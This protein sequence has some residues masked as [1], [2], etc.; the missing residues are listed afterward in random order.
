MRKKWQV[1]A[2]LA[3]VTVVTGC[4]VTVGGSA[5]PVPGQGPVVTAVDACTLLDEA[6][7]DALGFE[8]PGRSVKENKDRLQPPMCLWSSKDDIEPSAVLNVGVAS[9]MDFNEYIS[10]AVKKSE[11][12][13]I[14]GFSWTQ[15]ASILPDDCAYYALLGAKSFAYVSVSAGKLDKSCELA[16][17]AIPQVAAHLPGGQDAP[18]ITPSTSAKPEPGGPLLSAD[19]CA[20]LKPDQVSQLANISP[21]GKKTNSSVVPNASYCL[22]DD[23]DGDGGQKA[24]EVWYGPSTPVGQWPGAK[25]ITPVETVD[26]GGKKWGLFPNMGGLRVTCG[27]TVAIT[28]TSSVQVV[29][30]FIGDDTK[31]CDLVKQG[32]P[33]VTANLPG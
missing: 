22:W 11:P 13:R 32:L 14:S 8:T 29:S 17:L 3:A 31:T 4:T 15:Y 26:V 25:G 5:S 19:P 10:G 2:A 30:G 12:Q 9:D 20:A 16:K 27:A 7:V 18:P 24:F 33:L 6:Q 28:E 1:A 21:D 23:T